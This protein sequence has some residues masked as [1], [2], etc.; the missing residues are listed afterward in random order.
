MWVVHPGCAN[1]DCQL[2]KS[3]SSILVLMVN[4]EIII[5]EFDFILSSCL[6]LVKFGDV[7]V[8]VL[9]LGKM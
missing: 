6:L 4:N 7:E 9:C 3:L 8:I 5:T 1:G 2:K